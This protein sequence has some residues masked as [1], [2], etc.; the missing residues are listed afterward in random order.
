MYQ[1]KNNKWSKKFKYYFFTLLYLN[2]RQIFALLFIRSKL[3]TLVRRLPAAP[4]NL[5]IILKPYSAFINYNKWN[6][7]TDIEKGIFCFLNVSARIGYPPD[8]CRLN[9]SL[10]WRFNLHYFDY[11]HLLD[12][13]GQTFLCKSWMNNSDISQSI[14]YH[15][16]TTSLRIINWC[17]AN[18]DDRSV[19]KNLYFQTAYLYRNLEYDVPGNHLLENAKALIVGGYY[20]KDQGESEKWIAKGFRIFKDQTPRQILQDGGFFE[21]S[22]MYH[23]IILEGY[24]DIL[25]IIEN[26]HPDRRLFESA[27]KKMLDFLLSVTHP[28][29]GIAL[30]NDATLEIAPPPTML[31]KYGRDLLGYAPEKKSAFKETGYYIHENDNIYLIID[32]GPLGPDY[33]PGH[34]HADIFSYEFSLKGRRVIVDSGVYEYEKS[35]MRDYVRSTRAHNTV[36]MDGV[37]QAEMWGNFRVARR[38]K[39]YDVE[40]KNNVSQSRFSGYFNGYAKLIGDNIIHHREILCDDKNHIIIVTDTIDGKGNHLV[41]SLVHIHP[42][43][44]VTIERGSI[45]LSGKDIHCVIEPVGTRFE[46]SEGW[47]CPGFGEKYRNTVVVFG[48]KVE[49]PVKLSYKILY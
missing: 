11:I 30:F 37:D 27:A 18:I 47:Y 15:P 34:A 38:Y 2:I 21:R 13:E 23:S 33:I 32:G 40:F 25:N 19:L 5:K 45:H 22:P 14:S 43:I 12:R 42:E 41:E 9:E 24:L 49:L 8:W 3:N 26:D 44:T 29:G 20:F 39:P 48:G 16:Y 31:L 35:P 36:C 7:K 46:L 17:K 10:L 6:N 1:M 28:D 4:D